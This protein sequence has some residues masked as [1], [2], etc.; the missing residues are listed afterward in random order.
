MP[1]TIYP[2]P[3]KVGKNVDRTST[4]PDDLLLRTSRNWL[5]RDARFER[6]T[7]TPLKPESRPILQS[8]FADIG[9]K[10][11]PLI[12][13]PN[14]LVNGMIR[15]FEQ[16]LH[17]VLRPDDIWL[18]ILT[19]F[20]MYVNGHSEELRHLF[21]KHKGQKDLIIDTGDVPIWNF[22]I[23]H[24]A[25]EMTHL[26]SANVVDSELKDWIM[27]NFTTTTD[28]DKSTAAI[29]M[30]A[31][32]QK[33]FSFMMRGG[34]GFPSVKLLGDRSDWEEILRRV[35]KLPK[36]GGEAEEWSKLL[37]PIIS[38]FIVSFYLPNSE[39]TKK[40]WLRAC[41][42][43]GQ[44]GSG[45][46]ETVSGWLTAFCFWD[47]YGKRISEFVD[48]RYCKTTYDERSPLT[49]D[50]IQYPIIHRNDIPMG[51]LSVPVCVE[52]LQAGLKY[53]T[54]MVAGL[55][56]MSI[57]TSG[58]CESLQPRCG[59]WMLQDEVGPLPI[60]EPETV[61]YVEYRA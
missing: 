17:L 13:Y 19:Q 46:I 16:D 44:D 7:N 54:T 52:D 27:P 55:V 8:S 40:F 37:I 23:G 43:V 5:P 60:K 21:V 50:K 22:N 36:Y 32:T 30:M 3:E 38:R 18:S 28:D 39:E 61:R 15:A 31:T 12:P 42:A 2:S 48:N 59:W 49:L 35:E 9:T 14:G 4:S 1:V 45:D 20:G 10:S 56:G 58:G 34:C 51:T 57:G 47:K 41:H 11:A 24:L 6:G 53:Q 26:I 33:Y 25:Q 29:L